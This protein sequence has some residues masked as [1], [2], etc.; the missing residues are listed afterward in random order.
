MCDGVRPEAKRFPA[1]TERSWGNDQEAVGRNREGAICSQTWKQNSLAVS[2]AA[3][4]HL[5]LSCLKMKF[6]CWL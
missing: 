1:V 4:E 5:S 6:P 3:F 2:G